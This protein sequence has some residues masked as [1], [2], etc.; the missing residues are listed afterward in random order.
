MPFAAP[1][2]WNIGAIKARDAMDL[3]RQAIG[4]QGDW[5]GVTIAHLDT[6]YTNHQ[7]FR[8][9]PD[10]DQPA[11]F[12]QLGRNYVD[13]GAV[14]PLDPLNYGDTSFIEPAFPGHGTRTGGVLAGN[15][16]GT[17]VGVGPSIPVVPY[18]IT[19]SIVLG[20]QSIQNAALAIVDAVDRA[21]ADIISMSLGIQS[22]LPGSATRK[23][24]KQLG[25]AIDYAYEQG[26]ILVAA[27]GQSRPNAPDVLGFVAYPAAYSRAIGVGGIDCEMKIC[28][29]YDNY[30]NKIDVWAPSDEVVRPNALLAQGTIAYTIDE[31]GGD[32]TSYGTVHVA[33]AA[34]M[35]LRYHAD[36][37]D[38]DFPDWKRVEAFRAM[39][40][41][42]A[43]KVQ[44]NNTPF[45]GHGL[46]KNGSGIL[47]CVGLLTGALPDPAKL[48]K[49]T[50]AEGEH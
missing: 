42:T 8:L 9:P 6:G 2:N 39:L 49:A 13:F 26:K 22:V 33:A 36:R 31:R 7:V 29:D 1:A 27:G 11:L 28:F 21:G 14:L 15:L 50:A 35:W 10:S 32:G 20:P 24:M 37:L 4:P 16:P 17:F 40:R 44:G 38:E 5:A 19:N 23:A 47:D 25:R 18:R 3:I 45:G 48:R 46:P 12:P 34:A 43:Q 41:S 30:R